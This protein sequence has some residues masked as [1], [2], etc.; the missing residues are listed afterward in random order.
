MKHE[1]IAELLG[2][3]VGAV[4]VRLHRAVQELREIFLELPEEG[5]KWN[6]K[7]LVRN[8]QIV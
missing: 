5:A 8:L 2:I 6:A 4:K 1:Q 3:Q 7:R